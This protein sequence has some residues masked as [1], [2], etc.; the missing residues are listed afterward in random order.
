M[1]RLGIKGLIVNTHALIVVNMKNPY[2][3]NN[4]SSRE[5]VHNS[6]SEQSPFVVQIL[7]D[8]GARSIDVHK[9]LDLSTNKQ[10]LNCLR[11]S[12]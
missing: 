10:F 2:K 3:A 12:Y 11:M 6:W 1:A 7:W 8:N 5:D 9:G 4:T